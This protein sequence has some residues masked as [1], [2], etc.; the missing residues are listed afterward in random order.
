MNKLMEENV[1]L[2]K[3][4][5]P[6]TSREEERAWEKKQSFNCSLYLLH[7][8]KKYAKTKEHY[9]CGESTRAVYERFCDQNHHIKELED[10]L[11]SIYVGSISNIKRPTQGQIF[12]AEKIITAY[13]AYELGES[14]LLNATNTY[15][16]NRNVYIINEWWK[17]DCVSL[18]ERQPRNAPSHIVPDVLTYHSEDVDLYGCRKLKRF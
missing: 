5:G 17:T 12:L 13:L 1:F 18:W 15:F 10:R 2:I 9:Y 6:F 4:Y 16:P 14:S 11:G 7:G 8:K 3:W